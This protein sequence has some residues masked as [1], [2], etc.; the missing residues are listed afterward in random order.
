LPTSGSARCCNLSWQRASSSSPSR[1]G[2]RPSAPAWPDLIQ[3]PSQICRGGPV[4]PPT[5]PQSYCARET[6]RAKTRVRL[7]QHWM[8]DYGHRYQNYLYL[9]T[10][11]R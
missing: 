8:R 5:S 2:Q 3:G 10:H 4:C 11:D 1:S 9:F 6:V 7:D